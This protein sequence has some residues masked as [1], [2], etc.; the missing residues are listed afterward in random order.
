M[1]EARD[2]D[3][4][5]VR[6]E[7]FMKKL[8]GA[9]FALALA[10]C[11]DASA[12]PVVYTAHVV[13]DGE[14]GSLKFSDA[15]LTITF[16]GDT[17]DVSMNTSGG[18]VQYRI[19]HGHATVAVNVQGSTTVAQIKS[20][21]IYVHYEVQTGVVG[22]GFDAVSPYY[23]LTLSCDHNHTNCYYNANGSA[24]ASNQT[25][26]ALAKIDA[27]PAEDTNYSARVDNLPQ[28]LTKSTLL[29]GYTSA[30]AVPYISQAGSL[31]CTSAAPVA[32]ET[33]LGGLYLQDQTLSKGIFT[34]QVLKQRD[35]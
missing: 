17:S 24:Y 13:T 29:T 28:T 27:D 33:N 23:P 11:G 32:I 18:V 22:F 4:S 7:E 5:V 20:G 8:M 26:S 9:G 21:Q 6:S 1:V 35:D 25:V 12:A 2:G 15:P 16:R 31:P 34:V 3:A 30:C 10:I 19:D 14:L